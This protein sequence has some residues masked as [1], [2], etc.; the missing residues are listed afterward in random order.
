MQTRLEIMY[1]K[2]TRIKIYLNSRT[3]QHKQSNTTTETSAFKS[4]TNPTP[5][6]HK[7]AIQLH[8]I[9]KT[10][11]RK[12]A[13]KH[14][15]RTRWL[16]TET[17]SA[18]TNRQMGIPNANHPLAGIYTAQNPSTETTHFTRNLHFSALAFKKL[19]HS[20][21]ISPSKLQQEGG[22]SIMNGVELS[23]DWELMRKR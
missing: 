1:V 14:Q 11:S 12:Q 13:T 23:Y 4:K 17:N 15:R 3:S 6:F 5:D 21:P 20:E 16:N 22:K 7:L 10:N 19:N 2:Q 9:L 18:R 8:K